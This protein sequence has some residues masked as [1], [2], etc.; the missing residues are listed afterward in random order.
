[1]RWLS[2]SAESRHVKEG[3][4]NMKR[5]IGA[6]V[7]SLVLGLGVSIQTSAQDLLNCSDFA[8]DPAGAQAELARDPSDP[9]NLDGDNDGFACDA[10]PGTAP[11]G[12][13]DSA[14][15]AAAAP[16]AP[17]APAAA[18]APVVTTP[19]STGAGPMHVDWNSGVLAAL[20]GLGGISALAAL[21]TRRI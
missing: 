4:R 17:A 5:L 6:L 14:A 19:P 11:S 10:G 16:A 9:N 12:G 13:G 8:G 15:P 20:L 3:T 2:A 7:V 1:M 21:R 18:A